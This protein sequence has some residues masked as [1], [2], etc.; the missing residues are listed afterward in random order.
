LTSRKEL[1]RISPYMFG[2]EVGMG[3][4]HLIVDV[5]GNRRAGE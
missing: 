1:T 4:V 3:V 5:R 2:R